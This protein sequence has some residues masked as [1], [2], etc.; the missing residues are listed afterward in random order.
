MLVKNLLLSIRIM[1]RN[2]LFSFLNIVGLA[3]G[4]ACT[5]LLY[6]WIN[7][8]L[9]YNTYHEKVDRIFLV[10]HW[11]HY[12]DE[13][14]PVWVGPG[15]MGPAFTEKYPEVELTARYDRAYKGLISYNDKKLTKEVVAADPEILDIFT[16]PF[17][18]GSKEDF[19]SGLDNIII[20]DEVAKEFFGDEDPIGKTLSIDRK[21]SF[22]VQGVF[23]KFPNNVNFSFD[24]L[25]PFE[26]LK[27]F[28]QDLDSWGSNWCFNFTLLKEGVNYKEFEEKAV[29]FLDEMKDNPED[30]KNEVFLNPMSR[31]YLYDVK[32]GGKIELVRIFGI[33][34][35]FIL[36]IACFNYTNLA[37]ARAENRAKEIAIRKVMSASRS[38]L[39][40]QFL[41]ESF[42]FTFLALNFS[43]IIVQLLLPIFNEMAHK[44]LFVDYTSPGLLLSLFAIWIFTSIAAGIYPAFVLSS[45]KVISTLKGSRGNGSHAGVFRKILVVIQFSLSIGLIISTL[46]VNKQIEFLKNRDLK[47][48]KNNMIYIQIQGKMNDRYNLIK[49]SLLNDPNIISLTRTSHHTPYSV[50]S[51]GGGW[52]WEGKD[53]N[54]SPLVSALVADED[55][56]KTFKIKLF[57]GRYFSPEFS[58]DTTSG[59]TQIYNVVINE[60]FA[61]II[62]DNAVEKIL[63]R[64]GTYKFPVIGVID[65]FS[66]LPANQMNRPLAIYFYEGEY[67]YIFIRISGKETKKTV[68][69]IKSVFAEYNPGFVLEYGFL[70]EGYENLYKGEERISKIMRSFT[71][72]AI[73]ISCLGL[74]GLAAFSAQKKTKEIG[75]RKALGASVKSIIFLLSKEMTKWV[76]ISNIIAWPLAYFLMKNLL[77]NYPYHY[78]MT[79]WIFVI[80][81]AVAFL[82]SILTVIYQALVASLRNPVDSLRY[83]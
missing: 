80:S 27:D 54:V 58:S 8:E 29:T 33:I 13:D 82:L 24:L 78:E 20:S 22:I 11:Q 12:G 41:G 43:L 40:K 75:I 6:L 19:S 38:R 34:A 32:G 26:K 51:N 2:K 79:I 69:H 53:P 70:N 39:I 67:R 35:A 71:I 83:E 28:G 21:Y 15:P 72:F 45:F 74:F 48:D 50:G 52:Q 73:F 7:D 25:I 10:Q 57:E 9:S 64:G 1:L 60:L 17:V 77:E 31:F 81:G 59:S 61:D 76:L 65:N 62:G 56:I 63:N 14:Y 66:Y 30:R 47:F 3:F 37:T 18:L 5:I 46:V 4:L 36:I 16:C 44:E 55:F 42:V 23:K 49:Q 68:E